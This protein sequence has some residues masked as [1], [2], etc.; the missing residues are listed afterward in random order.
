[1]DLYHRTLF[2]RHLEPRSDLTDVDSRNMTTF[3]IAGHETTS[4][5]LSF[6]MLNLL[7]NP[8]AYFKAQQEVDEV[9]GRGKMTVDHLKS[10]KY[11]D[12]VLRE[13]LRLTPTAPAFS[14]SIRDDN[15]NEVEELLGGKYAIRRDDKV[16]C[17][18][19][20]AQRDPKVYGDDANEFKPERMT[21]VRMVI[22]TDLPLHPL[23]QHL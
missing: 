4:G 21:E 19:A 15:P 22:A 5:L 1:M 10:L 7:K 16:L 12:A 13:T 23:S 3:L 9:L 17:L 8:D 18:L 11:I 6:A 14:R 2:T 20:K